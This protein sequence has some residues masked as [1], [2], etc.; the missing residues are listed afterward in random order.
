MRQAGAQPS[1]ANGPKPTPT[2]QNTSTTSAAAPAGKAHFPKPTQQH[3]VPRQK[4]P[5]DP[6]TAPTQ[7]QT[8]RPTRRTTRPFSR[9]TP[10]RRCPRSRPRMA[11][12]TGLG[13]RSR[14]RS[15]VIGLRWRGGICL[16]RR[17]RRGLGVVMRFRILGICP[18]FI[19]LYVCM[20]IYKVDFD[21]ME[22]KCTLYSCAKEVEHGSKERP[23]LFIG[24]T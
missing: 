24:D 11:G 21:M 22:T 3:T 13:R 9:R 16:R 7:T 14:R 4:P 23:G 20:L 12:S 17:L 10:R 5:Q 6:A 1:A 19:D 15:G 18:S 2:A 8:R